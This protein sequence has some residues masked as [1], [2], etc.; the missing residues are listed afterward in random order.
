M[1]KCLVERKR[2]YARCTERRDDGY[3]RCTE[4]RDNGYN[5][6][7]ERRDNGYNR[8]AERRD[9]GY[10]SCADWR[11]RCCDWWPCSWL[12]E[13]VS[14]FCVAWVWVSNIVCVAWV[15]VSNIVCVAWV[16]VSNIVCVAW[17]WISNI[18]CVAWTWLE[19]TI[20]LVYC[21]GRNVFNPKEVSQSISECK[22][23]WDAA[24][25]MDE[26]KENCHITVTLR[27]KLDRAS[28]VTAEEI[29]G[30]I[31]IWKPAIERAWSNQFLLA[32]ADTECDCLIYTLGV[33]VQFVDSNEHHVVKVERGPGRENMGRWFHDTTG[34]TAAH[35]AGH[36]FGNPDEYA[37]PEVCPNRA[38]SDDDSIMASGNTVHVR[39][40][41]LFKNW[42]TEESCC[43]YEIRA[44]D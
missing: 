24:F 31:A 2:R 3:N 26:N 12:C 5:R 35:E 13:I 43:N 28:D 19:T 32:T 16:W 21:W 7:A 10:N 36:M 38:T 34:M 9:N 23:G 17:V 20:C 8:C 40:Y 25:R 4:R 39:H 29:T 27:I 11:S 41:Q 33:D 37:E 15:W 44:N 18:V 30:R 6:C 22:F 42:I 1:A 14:W